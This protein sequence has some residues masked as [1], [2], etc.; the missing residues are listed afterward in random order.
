MGLGLGLGLG[1]HLLLKCC[2]ILILLANVSMLL[3]RLSATGLGGVGIKVRP[4]ER[5][6]IAG[7]ERGLPERLTMYLDFSSDCFS[8]NWHR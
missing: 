3:S 7:A 4:L 2:V 8:L 5:A 1:V 6:L